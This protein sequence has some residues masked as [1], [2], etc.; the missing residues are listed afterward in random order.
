V[1]DAARRA[2]GRVALLWHNT[3]L[4]DERAPGYGPLWGG[5]LDE[6]GARGATMGAIRPPAAPAAAD[7]AGRRVI[8]LTTVHR[9]RDVR[10]FHKEVAALR[11]AGADAR[12]LGLAR[13]APRARRLALGW[14]LARLARARE[15]D[16]YHVHDPELLPAALW[17][18]RTSGRPV[19]YD[20]HEYLG[21][22]A[23][24]K[25]WLPAPLRRPVAAL[26]AA[27][28]KGAARRLS[29]VVA[30]NEDLGAR[31]ADAGARPVAVVTNSPWADAFP[32]APPPPAPVVL[33]VGG[34]GPLRGLDLMK[35]AFPLVAVPG[36]RL[37]LAGR[38]AVGDLPP[39]VEHLGEVDHTEIPGLLARAAVCWIPLRRHPN[40]DR[41]VP[42]K[43]VEAMA[44][45]RPVV[46]SDLPRTAAIVRA[47]GCGIVVP[48]DDAEAHA[49]A[50]TRLLADP[51]EAAAMGARGRAAFL[52]GLA[53]EPQAARLTRFYDEVLSA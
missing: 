12:V 44:T 21:Q 36:A 14:R 45:G 26:A 46:A 11:E 16:V 23:R 27:V 51:R 10:I 3:Y 49:A 50:L 37:V 18:H 48:A 8:H 25:R 19:V 7:L 4:A 43:L 34:L 28:E 2:G 41:A 17:L 33:Y 42:T 47:A 22:T 29:G 24:T 38:G 6:L 30:V 9:P 53:F 35:R 32:A 40:Y 52:A 1:L 39:R 5:L 13:P 31:F 20:V 15:A